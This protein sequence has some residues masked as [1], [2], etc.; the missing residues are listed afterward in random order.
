M[1]GRQSLETDIDFARSLDDVQALKEQNAL[2]D[3]GYN[4]VA[5]YWALRG[6]SSSAIASELSVS[7]INKW[8]KTSEYIVG[9]CCITRNG[10]LDDATGMI[11]GVGVWRRSISAENNSDGTIS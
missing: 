5:G 7:L 1:I 8:S 9:S 2:R 4:K 10:S 11:R 3:E 6:I